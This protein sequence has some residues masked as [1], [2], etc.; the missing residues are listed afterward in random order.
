LEIG[1]VAAMIRDILP[2]GE[3]VQE[4]WNEFQETQKNPFY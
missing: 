4:I 1:Q 3:I 2:A